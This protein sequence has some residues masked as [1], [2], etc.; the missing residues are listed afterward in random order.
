M[1]KSFRLLLL[2]VILLGAILAIRIALKPPPPSA[3]GPASP[4]GSGGSSEGPTPIRQDPPRSADASPPPVQAGPRATPRELLRRAGDVVQAI[5]LGTPDAIPKDL[6]RPRDWATNL[7]VGWFQLLVRAFPDE[8]FETFSTQY[9]GDANR[10]IVAYWALG[11]LAR[12]KHEATFQLFNSQL[13]SRDP[14]RTRQAL[15]ALANYDTPQLGPRVLAVVPTDPQDSD[16]AELLRTSLRVAAGIP[17]VDRAAL[18]RLLD[19]FDAKAKEEGLPN[20]YGTPETRLR[21]EVLRSADLSAALKGVLTKDTDDLSN[22]LGRAQWAAEIAVRRGQR[23]VVPALRE[24]VEKTLQHL[25]ENDRL[26][27]L[28][29]LGRQA[30]GQF[31]APSAGALGGL[32]EVRAIAT[33]RRAILDLGGTLSEEERRWLDGLRL[34]RSPK[35]YL[36]GAGLI[37]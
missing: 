35:E 36:R 15:K 23:E 33:L 12:L 37:E 17:S 25:K 18:D 4:P 11:E 13:E 30:K 2:G 26:D 3:P 22:D 9:L 5:F 10:S 1:K 32:E 14:V 28:D 34:L 24:R 21:A 19:Q 16:E 7:P 8:A 31:D 20:Y 27:E 29:I 6:T